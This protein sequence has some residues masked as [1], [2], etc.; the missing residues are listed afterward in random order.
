MRRALGLLLLLA[1]CQTPSNEAAQH[2]AVPAPEPF[3][4]RTLGMAECFADPAALPDHPA[5][6]ADGRTTPN[7]AQ[8]KDAKAWWHF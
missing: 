4:T 3:C 1:G 8:E 6:L 2:S 5:P 7:P